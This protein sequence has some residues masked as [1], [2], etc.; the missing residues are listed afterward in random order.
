MTHF[1]NINPFLKHIWTKHFKNISIKLFPGMHVGYVREKPDER[2]HWT[3]GHGRIPDLSFL[4]GRTIKE[5]IYHCPTF[6]GS[7]S[8][9][10]YKTGWRYFLKVELVKR[11]TRTC[12]GTPDLILYLNMVMIVINGRESKI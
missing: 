5:F 3:S 10:I 12:D 2:I 9:V 8:L 4:C 6:N 7:T 11:F 1:N